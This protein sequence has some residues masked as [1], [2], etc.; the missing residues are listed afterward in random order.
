MSD[1]KRHHY[2]PEFYQ[3]SW[4]GPDN[5]VTVFR[6]AYSGKLDPQRK[7]RK[8]VGWEQDLY[9][10]LSEIDPARRQQVERVF[11]KK[12]DDLAADALFEMLS[13]GAPP[14]LHERASGWA[15][16][17]MSLLHRH[18]TRIAAI[19]AMVDLRSGEV[20][21]RFGE[22]YA[23][24]R[25][26]GDP[27]TFEEYVVESSGRLA[28]GMFAQFLPMIVDS[29]RIGNVLLD[30]TWAVGVFRGTRFRFLTSDRPL[31]TS[32]GLGLSESFLMLPISPISY[33][34]AA[35]SEEIVS[36]F[37]SAHPESVIKAVNHAICVQAEHFVIADSEAQA[38]FVDNRLGLSQRHKIVRDDRGQ[39]FWSHLRQLIS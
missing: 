21:A 33:F 3:K 17:L 5:K 8:A 7:A 23:D 38:R 36:N 9:A 16:F 37:K 6:R 10:D 22:N 28:S 26:E 13:T 30:M 2:L 27:E 11:M 29:E 34:L 14:A 39:I 4:M 31:M 1:P 18:P 35:K 12:V 15:R 24:L 32:D 20:M 19:R 25:E